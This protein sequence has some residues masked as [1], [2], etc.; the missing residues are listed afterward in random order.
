MWCQKRP[1]L[2]HRHDLKEALRLSKTPLPPSVLPKAH[3]VQRASALH[4]AAVL[5]VRRPTVHLG[6]TTGMD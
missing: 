3:I 2:L 4:T 1:L 6:L 5:Q